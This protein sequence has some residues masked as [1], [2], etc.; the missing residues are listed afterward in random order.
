MLALLGAGMLAASAAMGQ[1]IVLDIR[2]STNSNAGYVA[3]N[4]GIF[5]LN[6]V[7]AE[8]GFTVPVNSGKTY[9]FG[10]GLWFGARKMVDGRMNDLTFITYNPNSGASWA[11]P[12]EGYA[13]ST[14]GVPA[15]SILYHSSN[16]DRET[17]LYTGSAP[18]IDNAYRWPLWAQASV[19]VRPMSPGTFVPFDADRV[20]NAAPYNFVAPAFVPG[21]A[22]EFVARFHDADLT[23]Y[24]KY[25]GAEL[26]SLG[27][28]IGLQTQQN[29]YSWKIGP[30]KNAVILQ[31]TI[32]NA[33]TDTLHDCVASQIWDPDLGSSDNDHGDFYTRRPELRTAFN[34]TDAEGR[35]DN[36]Y[37]V[38]TTTMLEAPMIDANGFVDN[39]RRADFRG[40]GRA[41]V[42][43]NW[44]IAEDPSTPAQRYMFISDEKIDRDKGAGDRRGLLASRTFSMRP[45]DTAYFAI[46]FTVLDV[47]SWDP[48]QDRSIELE[49][50]VE[51][52]TDAYYGQFP[53]AAAPAGAAGVKSGVSLM[54]NP[55]RDRSTIGFT[56]ASHGAA[57]ISVVDGLGRTVMH[58]TLDDLAA[59]EHRQELDMSGVPQGAYII[60]VATAGGLAAARL[61]V[62]R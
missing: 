27:Y 58:T 24:E 20:A 1:S 7:T 29:I 42:F 6:P 31:Y 28:P 62:V 32:V 5:G 45:G 23:R 61:Q 10:S 4:Y 54:P 59:G 44:A 30:L 17:G 60:T 53:I 49:G 34:W 55:A 57:T 15:T 18:P 46:G 47:A 38:L 48:G 36:P 14:P 11:I 13:S 39:T 52:M 25:A 21:V 16:Y 9:F 19:P 56:M 2:H 40:E 3:T 8:S 33:G 41:G 12:G 37:G 50:L 22:E 26:A 51:T 43:K 35:G